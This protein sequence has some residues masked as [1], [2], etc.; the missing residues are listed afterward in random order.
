M[1]S[2]DFIAWADQQALLLEQKRWEELDLV[3]LIEEVKDL[4]NRHRD[5]LE[6]QLTRLLMHL[7]K[8]KYQPQNRST[9]WKA[10]IREARKQIERLIKKHPVLKIHLEMTFLECY[11]NA[12]E[13]ASDETEL[14]IDTFPLN[15]PFAVEQ[16]CNRAFFPD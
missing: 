10:T 14:S 16:V 5:A 3:H 11:L 15:C 9:S 7:L 4:G 8:W 13:D 12:R 2:Q 6:S 1:Y